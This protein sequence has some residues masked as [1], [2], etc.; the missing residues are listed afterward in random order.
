MEIDIRVAGGTIRTPQ[1]PIEAD[2]LIQGER[3]VALVSR[4]TD[5][6]AS[7]TIDATGMWVFPGLIDL[8]AHT[9]T[10]G[11][12]YKEDFATASEAA[13]RGGYTTFVDMPN[14]EPP[15]TTVELLQQKKEIAAGTCI[16]DWGH[17]AGATDLEE[18]PKLAAAGATGFKIFQVIGGY[19]HDPRL[20]MND[21]GR[22]FET[23]GAIAATGLPLLV[24]PFDQAVF[25]KISEQELAAGKPK[26]IDTFA[27][28]Y[29][30]DVIW[31]TAVAVL[32]EL[33][34]ETGVRLQIIH[35]HAPGSLRL[36]RQAK[37]E[38]VGVTVA[39]DPKYFHMRAA[40]LEKQGAR[41]LPGGRISEDEER[42]AEIW[43]SLADGTIDMIDSDH[44]P[45]TLEDL[46]YMEREPWVGPFGSPQYEYILPMTLTDSAAGHFPVERVVE[47][48]STNPAK[49]LGMY[50]EKGALRPGSYADLALV[51]PMKTVQPSD[52]D[53]KSK[54]GWTPYI[55]FE[56][57]GGPV[58][59]MLRGRVISEQGS[60]VVESGHARYVEGVRQEF[61]KP[62]AGRF[63]GLSLQRID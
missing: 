6:E 59:T 25:E 3:V 20:A 13:A 40:D 44:A 16:I 4:D 42:M 55:D 27:E 11:L 36:A 35:T 33:Q 21:T 53:T 14:V 63:Q 24:H 50:P 19:P 31:R 28:I 8:H 58:L 49:V 37:T 51:D 17:F 41:A 38:G 23:F 30:R 12:E 52:H 5:T 1:G 54:V 15:T 18:I 45:H 61:E 9:R 7:R 32:L 39:I 43:R 62:Q 46:E 22:L 48:L 34:R 57:K 29:V 47:L 60:V 2:L 56:F 26:N 10:P